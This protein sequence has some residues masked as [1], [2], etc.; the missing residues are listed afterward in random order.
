MTTSPQTKKCLFCNK[1]L[2]GRT[3]KKFCDDACRN[4]YNNQQKAKSNYSSYIRNINN[5]LLKNRRILEHIL[6][7]EEETVKTNGDKLLQKGFVFK[8]HTHTYTNQ[9]GNIYYYSYD[10]GYLPLENN[11]YLVVRRKEQ[12]K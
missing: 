10:Y 5:T 8:Y 7:A 2:R 6:P 3:D 4:S 1:P 12:Q 11:W 9:K